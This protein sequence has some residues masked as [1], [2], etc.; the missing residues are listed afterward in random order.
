MYAYSMTKNDEQERPAKRMDRWST[1]K[2]YPC[3]HTDCDRA[4]KICTPHSRLDIKGAHNCCDEEHDHIANS[5]M[6]RAI[7][8]KIVVRDAAL[9]ERLRLAEEREKA[10]D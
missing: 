6:V 2:R 4:A 7:V 8:R 9:L 3:E 10:N 1:P 5:D